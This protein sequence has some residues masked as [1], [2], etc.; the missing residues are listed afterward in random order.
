L[1]LIKVEGGE[2]LLARLKAIQKSESKEFN[3]EI[4][5]ETD[6]SRTV[7]VELSLSNLLD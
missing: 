3:K 6:H 4:A 7:K 2:D 1:I 5:V